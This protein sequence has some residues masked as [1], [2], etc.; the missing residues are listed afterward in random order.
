MA[1]DN[2][3]WLYSVETQDPN[4]GSREFGLR[5]QVRRRFVDRA[6][7]MWRLTDNI[8]G[9]AQVT[10]ITRSGSMCM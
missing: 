7:L 5:T 6:Y 9:L 3:G 4:V 1:G 10:S 2:A 8:D